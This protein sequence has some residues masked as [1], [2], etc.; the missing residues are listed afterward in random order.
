MVKIRVI[1]VGFLCLLSF[2]SLFA[3]ENAGNSPTEGPVKYSNEFLRIGVGAR[4]FGMG[5]THTAVASDVSAGYWNPAGLAVKDGL[6][7]PEV[8]LM[9]S[10][11]FA[12][13]GNYNYGAFSMPVD[14]SGD[15]RFAVSFLHLGVDDIP[16]TLFAL[17]P[18]GTFNYDKVESF[19]ATDLAAIFT[20]AW[21]FSK[22]EGLSFGT[23]VKIVYHAFGRFANSWGLGMDLGLKYQRK[24]FAAGLVVTDAT[25]TVNAWTYNTETFREAFLQTGNTIYENSLEFTRPA[26]KLGLA[27]EIDLGRSF[28]MLLSADNLLYFDGNRSEAIAYGGGISYDPRAGIEFAY[29]NSLGRK[30]A[31]LR[32]GFYNLQNAYY[33]SGDKAGET[34]TIL[35]PTA[36]AGILIKNFTLDYALA[37]IGNLSENLHSHVVSLKFHIQ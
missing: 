21:R 23:N 4:A 35:F 17:D 13:V 29:K 6:K 24:N 18:D 2:G 1:W 19:S 14:S 33:N 31:F 26:L 34:G 15:R 28:S 12:N 25:N 16:N 37:N 30:V 9:H 22:V 10:A 7:Y 3:Q 27:Y 5:N 8:I 11:Y 36:G 20:Y 32:G